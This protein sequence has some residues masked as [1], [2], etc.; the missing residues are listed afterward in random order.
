MS[1]SPVMRYKII[2]HV[3]NELTIKTRVSS[4][5]LILKNDMAII[6]DSSELTILFS[7]VTTVE[8]FRLHGLGRM[9]RIVCKERTIFLTAVRVNFF[10]Y[11][12]I[13][14]FFRTGE[15]YESLK[16]R[17]QKMAI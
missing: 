16:K 1:P 4:G 15:L 3:G 17:V 7:D 6:S 8:M 9:I 12:V 14:N 2:Y 13:I 5:T 10:G 11:F